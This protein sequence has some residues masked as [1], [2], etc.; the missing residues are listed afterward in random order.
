MS[1]TKLK[2][3][4]YPTSFAYSCFNQMKLRTFTLSSKMDKMLNFKITCRK[5]WF[6]ILYS[7]WNCFI[8]CRIPWVRVEKFKYKKVLTI[9]LLIFTKTK[10]LLE[11]S[12]KL[13][14]SHSKKIKNK[15]FKIKKSLKKENF[16]KMMKMKKLN[17][18]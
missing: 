6:Q 16:S 17:N 10:I 1:T 11:L 13:T 12:P 18:L 14:W 8:T 7:A 3:I 15:P 5:Y 4:A 9:W 2:N